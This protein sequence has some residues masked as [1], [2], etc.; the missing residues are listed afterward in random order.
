[1][2]PLTKKGWQ[3]SEFDVLEMETESLWRD[4]EEIPHLLKE[5]V[6]AFEKAMETL[7][8]SDQTMEV[9]RLQKLVGQLKTAGER[10]AEKS[11][12]Y[13]EAL[14][15]EAETLRD[16]LKEVETLEGVLSAT[17][18][19]V[20]GFLDTV[21]GLSAGVLGLSVIFLSRSEPLSWVAVLRSA[22]VLLGLT[23][24]SGL[25]A[26]YCGVWI[27]L[28]EPPAGASQVYAW[29]TVV[30]FTALFGGLCCLMAFAWVNLA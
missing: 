16:R 30:C 5:D 15:R 22:W 20:G 24:V 7:S 3:Q 28:P 13:G 14:Q 26:K 2:Q 21:L 27:H 19:R 6:A 23:L 8:P 25:V 9:E 29:G 1:M 18:G 10:W 4:V 17:Y 11:T 12:K